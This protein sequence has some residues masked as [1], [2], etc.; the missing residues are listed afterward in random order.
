MELLYQQYKGKENQENQEI[1]AGMG[2][3]VKSLLPLGQMVLIMT[4]FP[5]HIVSSYLTFQIQ[6]LYALQG[7]LLYIFLVI[8]Q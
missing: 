7:S 2:V 4:Q 3:M 6:K 1:L 5:L 8:H